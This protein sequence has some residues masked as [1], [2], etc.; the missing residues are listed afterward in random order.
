MSN[1][2]CVFCRIVNREAPADVLVESEVAIAIKPLDP[3]TPG[4]VLFIPRRHVMDAAEDPELTGLV[5]EFASRW[6]A[7]HGWS[8][9][10]SGAPFNLITSA[11]REATQ[12]V[13]HLHLHYVPRAAGDGLPLPWTFQQAAGLR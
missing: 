1:S 4:H 2:D 7:G 9:V 3:V 5:M 11:G 6:A 12:S 10:R 8:P 13:F